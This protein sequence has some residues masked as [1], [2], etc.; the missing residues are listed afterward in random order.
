[1][2]LGC[3]LFVLSLAACGSSA[4]KSGS[5]ESPKSLEKPPVTE[6]PPTSLSIF[7]QVPITD[8]DFQLLFV[9]PLKAK[10]PQ[11]TLTLTRP[12][13]GSQIQDL[14]TAG[15]IPDL[16]IS[17][18]LGIG[19]FN[20][21]D[22]IYDHTPLMKS[23]QFDLSRFEKNV[24]DTVSD[25]KGV[26][27]IPFAVQ[28][29]AQ[30]Y[31]KDIFDKFGVA[32]PKDGMTWDNTIELARK[33]TRTDGD[34]SYRGL[35]AGHINRIKLIKS[36]ANVDSKTEKAIVNND[37][38]KSAFQLLDQIYS[39]P[40]NT[41]DDVSSNAFRADFYTKKI[42]AMLPVWNILAE[43]ADL[44]PNSLNWDLAQFP[45][46]KETPNMFA[47]VD[48][49]VLFIT[50]TSKNKDAAFKVIQTLTSDDVQMLSAKQTG[51]LTPLKKDD[52]RG[53]LKEY[54]VVKGKNIQG[55]LK[56]HA[57]PAPHYSKYEQ[58]TQKFATQAYKDYFS[59][60][61]DLNTALREFEEKVNSYIEANK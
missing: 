13:K 44:P 5:S 36:L 45:Y 7:S 25:E 52:I 1:M 46:F 47:G 20:E 12:G 41:P 38:W 29:Y 39:I 24:T 2:V 60:K 19:Q 34:V 54:P 32:Y 23:N 35:D 53:A 57:A 22:L 6:I 31:N 27:A 50:K 9:E 51:R 43:L 16:I 3:L 8:T 59:K 49:H 42:V 15:T 55:V 11:L 17:W 18:N 30:Y 61:I 14:I 26:Y 4:E 48:T 58:P 56:S 40:G 28:L 10:Y 21:F 33:V 37:N